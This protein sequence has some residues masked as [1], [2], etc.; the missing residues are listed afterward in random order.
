[1]ESRFN[2]PTQLLYTPNFQLL[3]PEGELQAVR[4]FLYTFYFTNLATSSGT[5]LSLADVTARYGVGATADP[6]TSGTPCC[7]PVLTSVI[8]T[9]CLFA[10]YH[11]AAGT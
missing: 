5:R 1:V 7:I 9:S 3:S 8:T 4:R 2:S 6:G 10:A 11:L